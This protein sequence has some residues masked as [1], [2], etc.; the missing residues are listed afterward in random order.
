MA[1]RPGAIGTLVAETG[2]LNVMLADSSAL[3]EQ[4]VLDVVQSGFNSAGAALFSVAGAVGAGGDRAARADF[5]SRRPWTIWCSAIRRVSKRISVRSST[6]TR[7]RCWKNTRHRS[8]SVRAGVIGLPRPRTRQAVSSRRW[9]WKRV[10]RVHA[11]RGFRSRGAPAQYRARDLDAVI[12][13]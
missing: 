11:A 2:G 13:A 10:A 3:A 6:T 9:P 8:P 5:I 4:L 7:L 1:A 12:A